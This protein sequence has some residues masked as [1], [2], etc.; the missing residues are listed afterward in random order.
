MKTISLKKAAVINAVSQYSNIILYIGFNIVLARL[1]TPEEFG[2]FAVVSIFT[3]FFSKIYDGGLGSAIIQR[4]DLHKQDINSLY[5]FIHYIAV[6]LFLVFLLLGIPISI[7]YKNPE[8]ILI[9]AILAV[10][11][12]F[13]TFNVVPYSYLLKEKRS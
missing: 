1:L 3:T 9:C 7:L 5:S 12:L 6:I 8:Y 11:I 10:S 2:I 13:N 4:I